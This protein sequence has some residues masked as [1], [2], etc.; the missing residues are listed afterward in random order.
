[1][2]K[3]RP[4]FFVDLLI[5]INIIIHVNKTTSFYLKFVVGLLSI[6]VSNIH[7]L[8]QGINGVFIN[9]QKPTSFFSTQLHS[10]FEKS[11]Q[12]IFISCVRCPVNYETL[13]EFYEFQDG[14]LAKRENILRTKVLMDRTWNIMKKDQFIWYFNLN[15]YVYTST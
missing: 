11:M 10:P 5:L 6:D 13:K 15:Y 14:I 8:H 3:E 1:M 7:L 4:R 9:V 12:W 2:S